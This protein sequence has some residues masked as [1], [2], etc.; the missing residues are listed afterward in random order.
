M[1]PIAE[2]PAET[3]PPDPAHVAE[4]VRRVLMKISKA[5]QKRMRQYVWEVNLTEHYPDSDA[6]WIL[7]REKSVPPVSFSVTALYITRLNM[8]KLDYAGRLMESHVDSFSQGYRNLFDAFTLINC[9]FPSLYQFT[10]SIC[11]KRIKW[12]C[13]HTESSSRMIHQTHRKGWYPICNRSLDFYGQHVRP[14]L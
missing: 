4:I 8:F 14:L 5:L 10:S 3:A 13:F 11:R 2:V 7:P 1:E 12:P 9:L 6:T